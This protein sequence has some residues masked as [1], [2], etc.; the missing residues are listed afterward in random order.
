MQIVQY[1][2]LIQWQSRLMPMSERESDL[3][4]ELARQ[5]E[6]EQV[7]ATLGWNS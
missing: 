4:G 2:G 1:R 6:K 7:R 3:M 5:K